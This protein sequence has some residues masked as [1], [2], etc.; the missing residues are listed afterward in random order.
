MEQ[1]ISCAQHVNTAED[2]CTLQLVK[3]VMYSLQQKP[4]VDC[5]LVQPSEVNAHAQRSIR[6][7]HKSTEAA[8]ACK[9]FCEVAAPSFEGMV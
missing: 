6:F 3:Q 9:A 7:C 4:I 1:A 2:L 8:S 5:V